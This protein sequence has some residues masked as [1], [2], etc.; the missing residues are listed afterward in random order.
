MYTVLGSGSDDVYIGHVMLLFLPKDAFD[1]KLLLSWSG[2]QVNVSAPRDEGI[3]NDD[4]IDPD[5][6]SNVLVED[7]WVVKLLAVVNCPVPA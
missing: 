6:T 1:R 4:G 2:V 7:C 3:A 5:S